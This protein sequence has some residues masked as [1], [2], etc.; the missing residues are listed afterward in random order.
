MN[1]F[2][3]KVKCFQSTDNGWQRG[4]NIWGQTVLGVNCPW[5]KQSGNKL[6]GDEWSW[7]RTVW[8]WMVRR[9][10]VKGEQSGGNGLGNADAD[11]WQTHWGTGPFLAFGDALMSIVDSV[12][13]SSLINWG[14]T[15]Q[16]PLTRRPWLMLSSFKMENNSWTG[17]ISMLQVGHP[18]MVWKM[19]AFR[20][21]FASLDSNFIQS[22]VQD[23]QSFLNWVDLSFDLVHQDGDCVHLLSCIVFLWIL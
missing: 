12:K 5:G 13:M 17:S 8:G 15:I 1:V 11:T 21:V 9:R 22:S 18:F 3:S 23:W 14:M 20:V 6:S 4:H 10:M 7:W 16:L 2:F 19:A